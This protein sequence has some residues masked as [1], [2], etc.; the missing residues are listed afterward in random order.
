MWAWI[1]KL[2]GGFIPIGTK[3]FPEWLGK[4][5][6]GVSMGV[7]AFLIMT[8]SCNCR[9]KTTPPPPDQTAGGSIVYV[10]PR[11]GCATI[12]IPKDNP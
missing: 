12:H 7:I 6:W 1:I 10:Q 8:T 4:V 5:I 11:F 3:P 9:K 2:I